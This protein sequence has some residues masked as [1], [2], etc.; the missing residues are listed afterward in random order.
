MNIIECS[1]GGYHERKNWVHGLRDYGSDH[2]GKNR[3]RRGRALSGQEIQFLV[4]LIMGWIEGQIKIV[5]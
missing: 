1:R 5:A 2:G 3:E 4:E